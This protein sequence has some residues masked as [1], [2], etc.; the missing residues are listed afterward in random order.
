M[1][2]HSCCR[3]RETRSPP[4]NSSHAQSYPSHVQSYPSHAQSF[5][6]HAQSYPFHWKRCT[7]KEEFGFQKFRWPLNIACRCAK[8]MDAINIISNTS[9]THSQPFVSRTYTSI[10]PTNCISNLKGLTGVEPPMILK[11]R[12][13]IVGGCCASSPQSMK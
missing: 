13:K 2:V 5:R 7:P 10:F 4:L 3:G 1:L 12:T 9:F 8:T 11:N 6:S